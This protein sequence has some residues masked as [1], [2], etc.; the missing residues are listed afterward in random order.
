MIKQNDENGKLTINDIVYDVNKNSNYTVYVRE[1]EK[2]VP[3]LVLTNDYNGNILLLRKYLLDNFFCIRDVDWEGSGGSYYPGSDVDSFLNN[4][5]LFKLTQSTQDIIFETDIIVTTEKSLQMGGGFSE[6][7]IIRRKIFILSA[8]E[9]GVKSGMAN[10]EGKLLKYFKDADNLLAT[11]E[12]HEP[13]IYWMRTPYLVDDI[14][15]WS[16]S[17]DGSWGSCPVALKQMI[18]PAFCVNM[19]TVIKERSDIIDNKIVYVLD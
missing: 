13:Q 9:L 18:R 6:I 1:N 17:Y 12:N 5:Y 3:Y 8:T 14:K 15:T 2:Y 16:V 11:D 10:I 4:E 7:E 19:N